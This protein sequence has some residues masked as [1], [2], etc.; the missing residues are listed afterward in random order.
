MSAGDIGVLTASKTSYTSC[1]YQSFVGGL[2][3]GQNMSLMVN[4]FRTEEQTNEKMDTQI[5]ICLLAPV[6]VGLVSGDF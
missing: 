6:K 3:V 2:I 4:L 1:K 5:A